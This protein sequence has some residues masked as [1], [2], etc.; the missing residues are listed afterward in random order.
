MIP[1]LP[2]HYR[3]HLISFET[4]GLCAKIPQVSSYLYFSLQGTFLSHLKRMV[5]RMIPYH[6]YNSQKVGRAGPLPAGGAWAL[7]L[8][9]GFFLQG[10]R[11]PHLKR[12]VGR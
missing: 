11:L 8:K 5:G 9:M 6:Y 1:Y 3:V 10:A 12:M 4:D 2:T 7:T